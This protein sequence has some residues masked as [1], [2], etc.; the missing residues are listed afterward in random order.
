M[1]YAF[2]LGYNLVSEITKTTKLLYEQNDRKDFHH[3]I[4]DLGFPMVEAGK[5]PDDFGVAK[6]NNTLALMQ[7][8]QMYGSE[9]LSLPN[10]GVSQNWTAVCRHINPK[11]DDILIG[12]DPDEHPQ[13]K[14]WMKAMAEVIIHG[15]NIALATL[16]NVNMIPILAKQNLQHGSVHGHRILCIPEGGICAW[17]LIGI[18]GKFFRDLGSEIPVPSQ[19]SKYGWIEQALS[20]K[21]NQ[22]DYN[23][24]L[25]RDYTEVHT[26]WQGKEPSFLQE[27][28]QYIVDHASEG[29][30][31]FEDFLTMKKEGKL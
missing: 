22:F 17:V 4:V 3:I 1:I 12:T 30:I 7:L 14:G 11:D 25:M 31:H 20:P 21:L 23:W 9:Y 24:C 18:S 16:M 6:F 13:D 5:I 10:I 19:G 15:G 2:T 26:V 8:A 28:K 29:Q 27:W